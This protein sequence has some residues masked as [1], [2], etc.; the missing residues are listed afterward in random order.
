MSNMNKDKQEEFSDEAEL[1]EISEKSDYLDRMT[2]PRHFTV[3]A[4]DLTKIEKIQTKESFI[5]DDVSSNISIGS[6]MILKRKISNE[7]EQEVIIENRMPTTVANTSHLN[8][9]IYSISSKNSYYKYNNDNK[10]IKSVIIHNDNDY[11]DYNNRNFNRSK[12]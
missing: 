1:D 8:K 11:N 5:E 12:K 6:D 10:S 4:N 2:I 3:R 9:S 7:T